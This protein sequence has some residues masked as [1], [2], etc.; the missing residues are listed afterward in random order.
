MNVYSSGC[1]KAKADI[2]IFNH[3][4]LTSWTSIDIFDFLICNDLDDV[5]QKDPVRDVLL[6][7]LDQPL[8]A[9]FCQ[10]VVGP[11]SVNLLGD[12]ERR[13][14]KGVGEGETKKLRKANARLKGKLFWIAFQLKKS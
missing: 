13:I 11:V 14:E 7:V 2:D 12:R 4:R 1:Q 10:V 3:L 5:C 8:V 6:Q 9:G